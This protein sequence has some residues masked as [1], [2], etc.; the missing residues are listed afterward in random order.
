MTDTK[1]R[2]MSM[3]DSMASAGINSAGSSQSMMST[4]RAL[5][6]ARDAVDGHHIWELDPDDIYDTRLA[7]RLDPSD[8]LDLR[9]SIEA[10]GQTVPILVRRHQS[11]PNKFLLVYGRRRLEAIRGSEKIKKIRALIANLD[12]EAALKAQVSENVARRDLSYIERAMFARELTE[13]GYGTQSQVAEVLN[14]TK[15]AISMAL[16]IANTVG[17]ELAFA[18]GPAHGIGRPRWEAF[19]KA[20]SESTIMREHLIALALTTKAELRDSQMIE[21][22]DTPIDSS[23]AAFEA[24]FKRLKRSLGVARES[25]SHVADTPYKLTLGGKAAGR[26]QRTAKGV[27]LDLTLEDQAFAAWIEQE[28]QALL[29]D[30]HQRW[31][32]TQK[33]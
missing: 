24:V 28:A 31:Q 13:K 10:N 33:N 15:S 9:S 20:L 29:Q 17:P 16:S 18:I 12:E 1:K 5:R 32:Q 14:A 27:K 6:S 26:V 2:R 19:A 7:D 25:S 11:E 21:A 23:V 22:Q 8:V 3:L 30:L 4:N